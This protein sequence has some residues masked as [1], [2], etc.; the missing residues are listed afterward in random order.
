MARDP[1]LGVHDSLFAQT[2]IRDLVKN[3]SA[4]APVAFVQS[5]N[6]SLPLTTTTDLEPYRMFTSFHRLRLMPVVELPYL[7]NID[8]SL[9][10][11]L[12]KRYHL[13]GLVVRM[14]SIPSRKWLEKLATEVE[15]TDANVIIIQST[16]PLWPPYK[17]KHPSE[18]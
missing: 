15:S 18:E 11:D 14:V 3:I 4:L 13:D 17:I 10:V 1:Q 8:Q 12:I 9:L 6:G 7:P 5:P 16:E 2:Q